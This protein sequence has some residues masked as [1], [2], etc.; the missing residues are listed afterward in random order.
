MWAQEVSYK[1]RNRCYSQANVNYEVY[2]VTDL[3]QK[4][5]NG[6][7]TKNLSLTQKRYQSWIDRRTKVPIRRLSKGTIDRDRL[8]SLGVPGDKETYQGMKWV[9]PSNRRRKKK[10][11]R[12]QEDQGNLLSWS[13]REKG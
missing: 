6:V 10:R 9:G 8:R 3:S 4:R 12:S 1:F 11:A 5:N 13:P 2:S 7:E